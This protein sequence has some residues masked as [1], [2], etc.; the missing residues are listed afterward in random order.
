MTIHSGTCDVLPDID[1]GRI[2][3]L[4][5]T[6]AP[7]DVSTVATYICDRGFRLGGG[8]ETR[9]CVD[10]STHG[11][12]NGTAPTCQLIVIPPGGT[13]VRINYIEIFFV[14]LNSSNDYNYVIRGLVLWFCHQNH[15]NIVP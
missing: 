3:Y 5:D 15:Q 7:Y 6:I 12:F 1:N 13:Y 4:P 11:N 2:E 10:N 8:N 9:E 14:W